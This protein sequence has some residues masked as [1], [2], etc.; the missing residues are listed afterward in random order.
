[1]RV[2]DGA[3]GVLET[4]ITAAAARALVSAPF[5]FLSPSLDEFG[6]SQVSFTTIQQTND[7]FSHSGQNISNPN[8][9]IKR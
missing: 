5:N 4:C 9:Q 6:D 3:L 2:G 8:V 7:N 1:M